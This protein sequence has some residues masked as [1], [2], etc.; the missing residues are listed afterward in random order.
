MKALEV[1]IDEK[2]IGIFVSPEGR[3]FSAMVANIPRKYMRAQVLASSD[4][5][6]C[7]WQLPD[8]SEGQSITFRMVEASPG[9]GVPAHRITPRNADEVAAIKRHAEESYERAMN[10]KR[11]A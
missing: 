2:I 3:P 9:D 7:Q 4:E 11:K 8:I 6:S 10:D 1:S 5:E